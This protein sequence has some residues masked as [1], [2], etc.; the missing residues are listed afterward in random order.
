MSKS[1]QIAAVF[2]AALVFISRA[3]AQTSYASRGFPYDPFDQLTVTQIM[4]GGGVLNVGFA[5]GSISLPRERIIAW[6]R[7]SAIA[8][9]TYYGRFP[10]PSVRVLIV[11]V[12]GA[13]IKGGQTF[14]Y[15]GP[16]IR[17]LLGS[18][19]DDTALIADWK[20]VHEMVHL[21]LPDVPD[22]NI[23]LAEGLAVYV[24]SIA[25]V[26]AG[27]LTPQ[28]IW[29]DFVRDMP[30]GLPRS[31]DEGLDKTHTWGRTY[32]GGAIYYL[33]ADVELR[34]RSGNK[35][36]LQQAMQGVIAAGGTHDQDWPIENILDVA[37]KA[38]GIPVMSELY[39][40]MKATP[41]DP[42]L[43]T[44]W[45]QL[46]IEGADGNITFDDDAPLAAIRV[47]ITA[48]PTPTATR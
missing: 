28:K 3:D 40:K 22:G 39:N 18:E 5:P 10:V 29:G 36:G 12:A 24:E 23:W 13:G 2:L 41:Y 9:T 37:D 25:R 14:G 4:V 20:A 26:Q 43:P 46:G 7:R 32:W 34:K 38:A 1:M 17:L 33:L 6:L 47:A 19:S 30:K 8:V 45:H 35:K 15:R 42:D 44:L 27:D 16:A 11:P 48:R 31:G 21:A